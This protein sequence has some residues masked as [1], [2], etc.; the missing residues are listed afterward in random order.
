M[1]HSDS[2][3]GASLASPGVVFHRVRLTADTRPTL[4]KLTYNRTKLK[5]RSPKQRHEY[6]Q[7]LT[8]LGVDF[9][10]GDFPRLVALQTGDVFDSIDELTSFYDKIGSYTIEEV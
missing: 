5:T 1:Q 2:F 4:F 7:Y 6:A 3:Q 8:I 9:P 10:Q